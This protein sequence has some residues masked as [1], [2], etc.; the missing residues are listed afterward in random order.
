M[1]LVG[2]G[3]Y[4]SYRCADTAKRTV[5]F[6]LTSGR[7][8]PQMPSRGIGPTL[9]FAQKEYATAQRDNAVRSQLPFALFCTMMQVA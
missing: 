9:A 2:P 4:S 1:S 6:W 3:S 8:A 5:R 7:T